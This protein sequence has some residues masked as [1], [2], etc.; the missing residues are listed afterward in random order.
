LSQL[1]GVRFIDP[2]MLI[3]FALLPSALFF[4]PV[5]GLGACT[6][7]SNGALPS[8]ARSLPK[9]GTAGRSQSPERGIWIIEVNSMGW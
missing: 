7:S 9:E 4:S 3:L 1:I 5:F 2:G 8:A 6:G